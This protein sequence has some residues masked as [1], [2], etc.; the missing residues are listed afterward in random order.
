[1]ISIVFGEFGTIPK[2]LLM[3]LDDLE[4]EWQEATIHTTAYWEESLKLKKTCYHSKS[5]ENPLKIH[6]LMLVWK[7]LKEVKYQKLRTWKIVDFA[8]QPD[9]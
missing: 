2:I 1:M 6:L 5:I 3:G 7:A 9:H 8:V 4:I